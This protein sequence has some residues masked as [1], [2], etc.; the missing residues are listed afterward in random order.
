MGCFAI[1]RGSRAII[2]DTPIVD[3]QFFM[4]TDQL[5]SSDLTKYNKIIL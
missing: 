1:M 4:E 5:D 3:G 2:N